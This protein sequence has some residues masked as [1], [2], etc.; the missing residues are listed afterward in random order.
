[1][2]TLAR[3]KCKIAR[4]ASK[5]ACSPEHARHQVK[6]APAAIKRDLNVSSR[7]RTQDG[8]AP[9]SRFSCIEMVRGCVRENAANMSQPRCHQR[10]HPEV[11]HA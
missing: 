4:G 3:I 5:A 8:L 6:A 1:M 9:G 10:S 7:L 11:A 2:S